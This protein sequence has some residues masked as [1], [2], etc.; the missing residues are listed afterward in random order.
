MKQ[1]LS[2]NYAMVLAGIDAFELNH[3][4]TIYTNDNIEII[5][6]TDLTD[7]EN[8]LVK[9]TTTIDIFPTLPGVGQW[10]EKGKLYGFEGKIYRCLQSHYRTIYTSSETLALFSV[11]RIEADNLTWIVGENIT[12]GAVRIYKT[13]KYSCI[14]AHQ[15]Q[16]SWNPELTLGTLW[17]VVA[18]TTEWMAGVQYKVGDVVTYLGSSYRCLQAHS[19]ISTWYPSVVPALWVKI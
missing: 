5:I 2:L 15:S 3:P 7:T 11:Y 4:S 12:L 16:D 19:S 9:A 13:K 18:T 14:Q 8:K 1:I 17:Q 10:I 6:G